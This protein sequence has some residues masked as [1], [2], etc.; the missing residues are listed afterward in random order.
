MSGSSFVSRMEITPESGLRMNEGV[1]SVSLQPSDLRIEV[2]Q[3]SETPV[4]AAIAIYRKRT[5][6][7]DYRYRATILAIAR[8]LQAALPSLGLPPNNSNVVACIKDEGDDEQPPQ[9]PGEVF[10]HCEA[11]VALQRKPQDAVDVRTVRVLGGGSHDEHDFQFAVARL[12][13]DSLTAVWTA[14]LAA[15]GETPASVAEEQ[16]LQYLANLG[17]QFAKKYGVQ[18]FP[19]QDE[20]RTNPFNFKGKTVGILVSLDA[21]STATTGV[22]SGGLV[23]EYMV[24]GIP[25]GLFRG[26]NVSVVL[27]GRVVGR[28]ANGLVQ[29]TFIG[30]QPC[31]QESDTIEICT[32][33]VH[34]VALHG[35][36]A[37]RPS[38]GQEF[39]IT[40]QWVGPGAYQSPPVVTSAGVRFMDVGFVGP[41]VPYAP[42]QRFRF[43]AA[44]PGQVVITFRHSG[45]NST[46]SDTVLVR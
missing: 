43:R 20:L 21:M 13:R 42:K 41:V 6:Q 24:S 30:M 45:D 11:G 10:H 14:E 5:T 22:F 3:K 7:G 33:W 23:G 19:N 17:Y 12:V 26:S 46:V 4:Y 39:S 18:V 9:S 2:A 31:G 1:L 35:P 44:A 16:R 36:Q 25:T 40:L 29:L 32:L 15:R 27:A 8:Y 38:V 34:E 37:P 28:S